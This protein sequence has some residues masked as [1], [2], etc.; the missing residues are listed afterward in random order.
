M[1]LLPVSHETRTSINELS[2]NRLNKFTVEYH[3]LFNKY[4]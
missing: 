3:L 1:F 2:Y 4:I